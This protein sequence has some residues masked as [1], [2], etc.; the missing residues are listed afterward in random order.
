[1]ASVCLLVNSSYL[2]SFKSP[3]LTV[4]RYMITVLIFGSKVSF[5]WPAPRKV[6]DILFFVTRYVPFATS[7]I[8]LYCETFH[9][10]KQRG[11]LILA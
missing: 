10:L 7:S 11:V 3:I 4:S 9:L 1:M 2:N 8:I 5:F 6:L